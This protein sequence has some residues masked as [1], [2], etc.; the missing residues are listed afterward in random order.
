[1]GVFLLSGVVTINECRAADAA[2]TTIARAGS[3]AARRDCRVVHA[4]NLIRDNEDV[5][6]LPTAQRF[7]TSDAAVIFVA[8]R[9]RA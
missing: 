5:R 7:R 6:S 8:S 2:R 4:F 9:R 3:V 1:M